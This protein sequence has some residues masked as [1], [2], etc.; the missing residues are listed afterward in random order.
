M[1]VHVMVMSG[2]KT[3][4][5]FEYFYNASFAFYVVH[6]VSLQASLLKVRF[7][8]GLLAC[9]QLHVTNKGGDIN[10]FDGNEV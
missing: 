7:S 4:R 8:R 2:P 5:C 6:E 3:S 10:T 1:P 9:L